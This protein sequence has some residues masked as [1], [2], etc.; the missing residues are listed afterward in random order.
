MKQA[1]IFIPL[2]ILLL[3]ILHFFTPLLPQEERHESF[4]SADALLVITQHDLTSR[5]SE[6]QESTLGQT[7]AALKYEIIGAELGFSTSETDRFLELM[8]NLSEAYSNPLLQ[9]LVG[10]EASLVLL[11]FQPT[12]SEDISTQ[13]TEHLLLVSRP[14]TP[15][16]LIDAAAWAGTA[17]GRMAEVRYGNHDLIRI[18]LED[19]RRISAARVKDLLVMSLNEQVLR[20]SLD[21]YDN[22]TGGLLENKE[23]RRKIEAFDGAS[24]IGYVDLGRLYQTINLAAQHALHTDEYRLLID[25]AALD[26]YRTCL[27]GAWREEQ[28]IVD[29]AIISF[30][31]KR[32]D[33]RAEKLFDADPAL[34][35]SYRKVAGDT[36]IYHWSNQFNP[37][38]FVEYLTQSVSTDTG[39]SQQADAPD[40]LSQIT[41]L[42]KE[43]LAGLF[44]S[45]LTF[46]VRS[47]SQGQLVPFPRFLLSIK[48]PDVHRLKMTVDKLI[49]HFGVPVR[50]KKT[51]QSEV[52]SWGGVA[53]IGSVLPTLSFGKNSIIVSSNREQIKR[54]LGV[55]Q[56]RSLAEHDSF[57]VLSGDLLKPS[58]AITYMDVGQTAGMLKE[59]ISWGATMLAIQDR[60]LARKSKV[61]IDEL[62]NPILDG[63]AMYS[64]IGSRKFIDGSD[65]VYESRTIIDD[66]N[67]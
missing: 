20:Q 59:M 44:G 53:G 50:R 48:S 47:L 5:V 21:I 27:F 23:Y 62:I 14:Q 60:E 30:D 56:A 67:K 31:R 46:V 43:Q 51:G 33:Q 41:G 34:P 26:R 6:F 42:T 65:I 3:A 24:F 28:A 9:T 10:S 32:F 22:G 16:R 13:I 2:F 36:I 52:I 35:M 40:Q 25:E 55:E 58:Q 38:P 17:G 18:Q 19:G 8:N 57:K 61:L 12:I 11:P 45:D 37:E 64:L 1:I 63:L 39:G 54:F 29:K 49:D 66:G 15:A 7:I 4:I